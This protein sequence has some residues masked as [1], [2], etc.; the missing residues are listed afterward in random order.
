ML[1]W[2]AAVLVVVG[3]AIAAVIGV[4]FLMPVPEGESGDQQAAVQIGGPFTLTDQTG[5]QVT[6]QDYR[7]RYLLVYFG[8]TFC[9]DLCPLGLQTIATAME[10]LP[11]EVRA[12][13]VP[14][15]ITVD[16]ARDTVPVMRD[17]V[18]QFGPELV[19]LTG[20]EAEID[21]AV[22][23]Y[24]VYAHKSDAPAPDGNYLVDH[25]VF[26]FLMDRD[27]RY[28]THFGHDVTPEEMSKRIAELVGTG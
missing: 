20:S 6:E 2:L 9:P 17:Y 13:V 8:Y 27:G 11:P 3:M 12:Q 28:L 23:A 24:R 25:S 16:P 4:R 22:R 15:F 10:D 26:T 14:L 7:G 1:R 5:K 18:A 19:G 21:Q